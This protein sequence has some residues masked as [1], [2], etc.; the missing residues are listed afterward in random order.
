VFHANNYSYVGKLR[1]V[2]IITH[3]ISQ[4]LIFLFTGK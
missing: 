1:R 4:A 2:I 3:S